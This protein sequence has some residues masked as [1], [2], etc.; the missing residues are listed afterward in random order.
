MIYVICEDK[1]SGQEFWKRVYGARFGADKVTIVPASGNKNLF[2]KLKGIPGLGEGDIVDVALDNNGQ[3][4]LSAVLWSIT[5]YCEAAGC[6]LS[7]TT[8]YCIEELILSYTFVET[9]GCCDD[10]TLIDL[11]DLVRKHVRTPSCQKGGYYV[12]PEFSAFKSAHNSKDREHLAFQLLNFILKPRRQQFG[13]EKGEHGLGNCWIT[14]CSDVIAQFDV[15]GCEQ[16]IWKDADMNALD[17]TNH[18]MEN[19]M[20]PFFMDIVPKKEIPL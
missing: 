20:N 7:V 15:Y 10:A 12:F 3:D 5:D 6:S 9:L 19:C 13:F 11:L 14:N 17:K 8:Y 16:C 18:F 1:G 2:G 4:F